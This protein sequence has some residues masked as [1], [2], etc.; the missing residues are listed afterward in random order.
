MYIEYRLETTDMPS[1]IKMLA[2]K[3]LPPLI[4]KHPN[5]VAIKLLYENMNTKK[6]GIDFIS[7][8]WPYL[9]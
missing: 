5:P 4:T 6:I 2:L 8:N 9:G 1:L 7:Q 3:I